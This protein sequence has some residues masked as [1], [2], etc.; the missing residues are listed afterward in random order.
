MR[1][2][3]ELL[4]VKALLQHGRFL[5]WLRDEIR[6]EPR[7]AQR[8]MSVALNLKSD[9]VSQMR[10]APTALYLLASDSTPPEVREQILDEARSGRPITRAEVRR[11]TRGH[12]NE[13]TEGA[14]GN[15]SIPSGRSFEGNDLPAP[16]MVQDET[17]GGLARRAAE[18][19]N[20]HHRPV[21]KTRA[22]R[23]VKPDTTTSSSASPRP[24]PA[25]PP[26]ADN[27]GAAK[28]SGDDKPDPEPSTLADMSIYGSAMLNMQ[29]W[30]LL[31][32]LIATAP[33]SAARTMLNGMRRLPEGTLDRVRAED[34]AAAAEGAQRRHE[35]ET[36]YSAEWKR[37][38]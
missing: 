5:A 4:R 26:A 31:Q 12:R 13:F 35:I 2:G 23:N 19:R 3:E 9:T 33:D 10:M 22:G 6:M 28:R 15:A 37:P 25:P 24:S 1:I 8:M 16:D 34:A 20:G 32:K 18:R 7:T 21:P 27:A 17:P 36:D 38:N 11:R 30:A 29:V 14:E